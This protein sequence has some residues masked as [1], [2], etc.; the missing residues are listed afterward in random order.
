MMAQKRQNQ[1][2]RT[3]QSTNGR[4]KTRRRGSGLEDAIFQATWDELADVGYARLTM[5]GIADRARTGKAA[6]YRRWSNRAELVLA[7]IRKQGPL[8]GEEVPNTGELREDLL[9]LLSR[10]ARRLQEI[11]AETINGLFTEY[12]GHISVNESTRVRE[13]SAKAIMTILYKAAER[14]EIEIDKI[15]P[16]IATLPNDLVRHELLINREPISNRAIVEI[17][18]D[19]F[20]PLITHP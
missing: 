5:E 2:C 16:R 7:A 13:K 19:I 18:D 6:V 1:G 8:M 11:G 20:L 10:F 14:G 9:V 12:V 3:D 15:T 4:K 17:V